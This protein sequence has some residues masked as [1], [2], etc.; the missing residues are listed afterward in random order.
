M[1]PIE[2]RGPVVIAGVGGSGTRAVAKVVQELGFFLGDCLNE[3]L[4][5]LWFPLL[6]R[7]PAWYDRA[8]RAGT[9][10]VAAFDLFKRAAQHGLG[11]ALSADER[12]ILREAVATSR[13]AARETIQEIADGMIAS[14]PPHADARGFGWKA[15]NSHIYMPYLAACF[16]RMRFVHVIRHGLDMA[17]SS[18]QSQVALWAHLFDLPSTGASVTP[19]ESVAYWIAANRRAV[20]IG[21][22]LLGER[23][24]LLDF[25]RLCSTPEPAIRRLAEFLGVEEL[26]APRLRRL[27]ELVETPESTGRYREHPRSDFTAEQLAAVREFGFEVAT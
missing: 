1:I 16:P 18:N 21:R 8:S 12:E 25:D 9:E 13:F 11:G 10:I 15:P 17:Y 27:S 14:G 24:L 4:D 26:D 6:F 5:N 3:S 7:R 2:H 22:R 23:F 20:S 19:R